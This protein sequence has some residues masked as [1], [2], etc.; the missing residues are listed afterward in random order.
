MLSEAIHSIVD[1][2]N[3]AFLLWGLWKAKQPPDRRHP[4]GYGRS[5]YFWS[6]VSAIGTFWLGAGISMRNSVSDVMSPSLQIADIGPETWM[7]LAFSFCIDGF[8]LARTLYVTL[9][10]KPPKISAFKFLKSSRDPT[11]LAVLLEDSAA[12]LGVLVA[13]GG[14][15][16]SRLTNNPV[17][18]AVS[19]IAISG[20]LAT[21]G[22]VLA[23]LNEKF[24][25]G[26]SVEANIVDE[27]HEILTARPAIDGIHSV[28]SQWLGMHGFTYKV[29][30]V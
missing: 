2:G 28:Q 9:Q 22:V 24:L 5:V 27:I 23:K 6:L 10:L 7:V 8:V 11:G 3:Q 12:C 4:Y 17:Y 18:D 14:L 25:V 13:A 20:L 29:S 26:Q 1:T 19:G 21:M 16:L 30:D 15:G